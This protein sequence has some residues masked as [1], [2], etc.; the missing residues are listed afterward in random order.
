MRWN[1]NKKNKYGAKVVFENGIRFPSILEKFMYDELKKFNILF[2]YQKTIE[3]IPP[4]VNI[5]GKKI[6]GTKIIVDF[7]IKKNDIPEYV[8]T[9]GVRPPISKL[10]Y[11]MLN[12]KLTKE[13]INHKI[14][15]LKNKKEVLEYIYNY[16]YENNNT[17]TSDKNR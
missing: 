13:K 16:K 2:E 3:L 11:K 1:I 8:D 5:S 7:V 10:K 4:F 14:I 12:Y 9:K 6:R 17:Q 15:F